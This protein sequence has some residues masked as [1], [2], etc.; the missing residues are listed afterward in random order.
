M[1]WKKNLTMNRPGE[2]L[3]S[4]FYEKYALTI[5]HVFCMKNVKNGKRNFVDKPQNISIAY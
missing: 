1:V 4:K 2:S 5:M 3:N